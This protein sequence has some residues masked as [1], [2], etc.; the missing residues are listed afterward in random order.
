MVD[1]ISKKQRT[2]PIA[3]TSTLPPPPRIKDRSG[4][5]APFRSLG[6]IS[7]KIPFV[8]QSQSSK[9]LETPALVV[10]TSLGN[11]WA[12]WEGSSLKLLFVGTFFSFLVQRKKLF[13]PWFFA[14]GRRHHQ[15]L[16]SRAIRC[17]I[18]FNPLRRGRRGTID[19]YD[20]FYP[21]TFVTRRL[22]MKSLFPSFRG[23]RG[24]LI[25]IWFFSDLFRLL[26]FRL[27]H[28]YV[29]GGII[30]IYAAVHDEI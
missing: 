9:F 2:E 23:R 26:S 6:H 14:G 19:R 5:F 3:S 20:D 25:S 7:T 22:M 30:L 21:I 8:V 16:I 13:F 24:I 4:L 10:I 1:R 17:T 12:M 28:F 11:S 15:A 29:N 27:H 18:P